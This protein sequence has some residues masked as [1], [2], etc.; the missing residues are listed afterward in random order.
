LGIFLT[1]EL[2]GFDSF[3][4]SLRFFEIFIDEDFVVLL[5]VGLLREKFIIAVDLLLDGNCLFDYHQEVRIVLEIVVGLLVLPQHQVADSDIVVQLLF[6][7][8]SVLEDRLELEE[9]VFV[10]F[11]GSGLL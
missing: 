6:A 2:R 9:E 1:L 4:R 10:L 8:D 5:L 3:G 11:A 7:V